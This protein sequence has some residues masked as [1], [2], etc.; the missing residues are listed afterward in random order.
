MIIQINNRI[1]I[2]I[3]AHVKENTSYI[4]PKI[5]DSARDIRPTER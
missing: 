2:Y 1:E 4:K 5:K 3:N